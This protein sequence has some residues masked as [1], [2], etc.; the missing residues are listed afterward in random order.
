[1]IVAILVI[2][3]GFS[4]KALGESAEDRP[5]EV[6]A[7]WQ[8]AWAVSRADRPVTDPCPCAKPGNEVGQVSGLL[9]RRVY[10][11]ALLSQRFCEA[12]IFHRCQQLPK[13]GRGHGLDQV[14]IEIRFLGTDEGGFRFIAPH[15][16][17]IRLPETSL[18]A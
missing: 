10:P 8:A 11:S 17:Q 7:S 12:V 9:L 5:L 18:G 16:D 3:I 15:G 4:P 6:A 13:F 1:M 2:V 14:K